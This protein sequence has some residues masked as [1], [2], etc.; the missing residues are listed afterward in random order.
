[1][2]IKEVFDDSTGIFAIADTDDIMYK[3]KWD[4]DL[5]EEFSC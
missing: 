3:L 5:D 1:M 4:D 2:V